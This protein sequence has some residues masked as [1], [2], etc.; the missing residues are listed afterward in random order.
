MLCLLLYIYSNI[1]DKFDLSGKSQILIT[2]SN[3]LYCDK[4][5]TF[6]KSCGDLDFGP[7]VPMSNFVQGILIC[8]VI[9]DFHDPS[10]FVFTDRHRDAQT[11]RQIKTHRQT[12]W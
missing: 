12:L 6:S 7:I 5:I 1:H 3:C 11:D 4:F 9:F 10:F 8:C 2:V